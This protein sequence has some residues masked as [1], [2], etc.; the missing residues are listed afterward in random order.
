MKLYRLTHL[1]LNNND[2]ETRVN[3]WHASADAASKAKTAAKKADR[4][5]NAEVTAVDVPTTKVELLKFLNEH[6]V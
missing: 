1:P 3:S 2:M 4:T 6:N 5:C